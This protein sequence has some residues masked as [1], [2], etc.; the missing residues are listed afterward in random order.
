MADVCRSCRAPIV[1]AVTADGKRMPLDAVPAA[2]GNLA[3]RR[4]PDGTLQVRVLTADL[5][6]VADSERPAIS[7]F[8]SCP[9]ADRHR[10]RGGP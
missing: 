9:D 6:D 3:A 7:H 2:D 8:A 5:P 4:M 10:R 1:W